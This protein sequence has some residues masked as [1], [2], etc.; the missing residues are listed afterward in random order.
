[1]QIDSDTTGSVVS[2]WSGQDENEE[3]NIGRLLDGN[4]S[5][6]ASRFKRKQKLGVYNSEKPVA[7]FELEDFQ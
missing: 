5:T 4:S 6:P 3:L 1:M 2:G 7:T